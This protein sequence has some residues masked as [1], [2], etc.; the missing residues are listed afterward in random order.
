MEPPWN[1]YG[2]LALLWYHKGE[3]GEWKLGSS[4]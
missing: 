4:R 2:T 3:T 1:S